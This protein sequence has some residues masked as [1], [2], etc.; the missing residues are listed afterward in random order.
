MSSGSKLPVAPKDVL[1]IARELRTGLR[2]E[3]PLVVAGAR[4]LAAVLRRELTRGG[5]ASSVRDESALDG[6]AVLVYLHRPGPARTRRLE[7]LRRARNGGH[8]D[9]VRRRRA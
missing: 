9:R 7:I 1:A 4:E 8:P 6:A 5:V 2:D 3:K